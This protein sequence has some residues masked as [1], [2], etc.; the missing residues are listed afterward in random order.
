[1][2]KKD[3]AAADTMLASLEGHTWDV[4]SIAWSEW[5]DL[6]SGSDDRTVKLWDAAAGK[7]RHR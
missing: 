4:Y 5:K 1:M 7:E 2:S 6:V 3:D